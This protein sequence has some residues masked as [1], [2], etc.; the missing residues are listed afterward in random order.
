MDK[1][2]LTCGYVYDR[3]LNTIEGM[4]IQDDAPEAL[5]MPRNQRTAANAVRT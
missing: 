5:T 1:T 4:K 3:Q 2:A